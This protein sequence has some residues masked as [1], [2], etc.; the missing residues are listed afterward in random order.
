MDG[1]AIVKSLGKK[2]TP[3]PPEAGQEQD[4]PKGK[5]DGPDI[6]YDRLAGQFLLQNTRQEWIHFSQ[7]DIKV[8]LRRQGWRKSCGDDERV[9]PLEDKVLEIQLTHDVQ[10]AGPL[11]G[12]DKGFH[13]VCG[14]RVLVTES[15]TL[16]TPVKGKWDTLKR[17][18]G[19]MLGDQLPYFFGWLKCGRESLRAGPPFRPGQ[20]IALCGPAGCGKS[21]LQSI[22]T[23]I[24]GGRSGKP[25]RY[26]CGQTPFNSELFAAEHLCIEDE[27]ASTDIRAR[28]EFGANLKNFTVNSL[29]S[30]HPKGRPAF[31]LSPFWRGTI[32]TNEE[33]E[34]LMVLP[35]L[36][37]S[38]RDKISLF[39]CAPAT[40][41][42][43]ADKPLERQLF[44]SRLTEELPAF[45]FHLK[46]FK[47]PAELLDQRYGVVAFQ[48]RDLEGE[49]LE[50][51]PEWR[52]WNLIETS[53]FFKDAF[54]FWE[55]TSAQL[56]RTLRD[57]HRPSE[58]DGLL[59][60]SSACGVFLERLTHRL[61]GR[62]VKHSTRH[63]VTTWRI[64]HEAEPVILPGPASA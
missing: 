18:L 53:G 31:L 45:L 42:F 50:L 14:R 35:P 29:H 28:R 25:Y 40:F 20:F 10:Y 63:N 41:P 52:L 11:A 38:L 49:L 33:P 54:P 61:R 37:E 36:D 7:S 6:Y 43:A 30:C 13:E 56:E 32:S 2:T 24:F 58:V 19:E 62:V 1:K 59:K 4:K 64:H 21:L 8:F 17:F 12:Y 34:N 60:Y 51:S 27:A 55:G 26:L 16:P 9:S 47:L 22:I 23:E 48:H 39:K 15:P 5:K 57:S 46:S 3:R 44:R